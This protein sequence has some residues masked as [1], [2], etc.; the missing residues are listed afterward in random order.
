MLIDE[1]IGLEGSLGLDIATPMTVILDKPT[2]HKLVWTGWVAASE[3]DYASC[4]DMVLDAEED[5]PLDPLVEM[6][7]V[8]NSVKIYL[9]SIEKTIGELSTERFALVKT[10]ANEYQYSE[11]ETDI[12]NTIPSEPGVINLRWIDDKQ[13]LTGTPLSDEDDPRWYYQELYFEAANVIREPALLAILHE[14]QKVIPAIA[15]QPLPKTTSS[16]TTATVNTKIKRL[17]NSLVF[18]PRVKQAMGDNHQQDILWQDTYRII[19]NRQEE[20]GEVFL[21][22]VIQLEKDIELEH[23]V[24]FEYSENGVLNHHHLFSNDTRKTDFICDP[25]V[26]YELRVIDTYSNEE[27][28]LGNV[29]FEETPK[30]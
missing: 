5:V 8:W 7:Q 27:L 18:V 15:D 19:Y 3:T 2:E 11:T 24:T 28:V 6:V 4:W 9:P 14:E 23:P 30:T 21:H 1:A 12:E 13:V 16:P 10:L 22:F 25:D 20:D 26:D 17:L 29:D